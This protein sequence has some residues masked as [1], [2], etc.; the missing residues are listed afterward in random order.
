MKAKKWKPKLKEKYYKIYFF[1]DSIIQDQHINH[2]LDLQCLRKNN[3]F[4]T[5]REAQIALRKIKQVLRGE[6]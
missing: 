6:L 3:C 4:K 5:K 2:A 1:E